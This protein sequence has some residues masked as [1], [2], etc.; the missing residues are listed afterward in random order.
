MRLKTAIITVGVLAVA[1][2]IAGGIYHH[3]STTVPVVSAGSPASDGPTTATRSDKGFSFSALETPRPL[4]ELK[5]VDGEGREMTL[6]ALEGEVVLLNIWATWCVPCR[7]EMPALDRLEARLGGPDFRVVPLSIDREGLPTVKAFYQELGLKNL[8]I[9]V[10]RTGKA[11]RQ[12][13]AVGIPTTLLVDREGRE[14]GRTVG[15]AKWDS[16]EVV[17]VLEKYVTPEAAA[18]RSARGSNQ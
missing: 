15:P 9:Y 8:G 1:A 16:D 12:L 7:E 10:D 3:Y 2:F 13:G 11:A 18:A 5:F 14:I 6:N 4:P 17:H